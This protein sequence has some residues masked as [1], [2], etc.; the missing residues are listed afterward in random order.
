MARKWD[1]FVQNMETTYTLNF[2]AIKPKG[3]LRQYY[4]CLGKPTY[5]SPL[6]QIKD[7]ANKKYAF[8]Q[9][10]YPDIADRMLKK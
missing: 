6:K 4:L 1:N 5:T 9:I 10:S 7:M 2:A 8:G 3:E